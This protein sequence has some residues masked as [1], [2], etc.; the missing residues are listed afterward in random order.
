MD[1]QLWFRLSYIN[2]LRIYATRSVHGAR[3]VPLT[4]RMCVVHSRRGRPRRPPEDHPP[5]RLTPIGESQFERGRRGVR[6][7]GSWGWRR[8]RT[9]HPYLPTGPGTSPAAV[10]PYLPTPNPLLLPYHTPLLTR[11]LQVA[12]LIHFDFVSDSPYLETLPGKCPRCR[13]KC[14]RA[15]SY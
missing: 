9:R 15:S 11:T 5:P 6:Q 3:L 7:R 10:Y 4:V 12:I 13:L 1:I 2:V 14:C 8:Q